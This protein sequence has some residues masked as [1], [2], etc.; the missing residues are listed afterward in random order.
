MQICP[1][2]GCHP[3]AANELGKII[4]HFGNIIHASIV[5]LIKKIGDAQKVGIDCFEL[6]ADVFDKQIGRP[7]VCSKFFSGC[8][9]ECLGNFLDIQRLSRKPIIFSLVPGGAFDQDFGRSFGDIFQGNPPHPL[10][11]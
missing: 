7:R 4:A 5:Y 11:V 10:S 8:L 2:P 1:F 9:A 3:F 6:G